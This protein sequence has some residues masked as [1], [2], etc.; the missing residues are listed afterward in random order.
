[1]M[2]I[3]E[4]LKSKVKVF[5][6]GMVPQEEIMKAEKELNIHFTDEY[7]T[8]LSNYGAISFGSHELTGLGVSGYLNVVTA[9]ENE[10]KLGG[11]FPK[12]CVLIE[13]NGIEG[14]LTIMDESGAIFSF[15]GKKK[16][17][18]ALSFSDF[19]KNLL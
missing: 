3:I 6:V 19:L 8:Y 10:R 15:D 13:N 18:I 5:Q 1:M 11:N 2:S 4:E 7:K 14:I 9:T 17:Q 12:N 16:N